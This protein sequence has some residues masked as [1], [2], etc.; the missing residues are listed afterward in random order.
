MLDNIF[1]FLIENHI[2]VAAAESCTG[3]LLAAAFTDVS[4]ISAVF[5]EGAVTYSNEAKERLGVKRE[6]LEKYGAVS[7][8]TAAEMALCIKRRAGS[9]IGISTTGAA[10]PAS[11]EGKPVGLVYTA[12]ATKN[13]T[14]V[15]TLHLNGTRRGIR[16]KAVKEVLNNLKNISETELCHE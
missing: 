11:S 2:T 6:T 4:G 8:E 5:L 10:G 3:G 7:E 16:E 13:K 15:Y 14:Y 1:E 12:I 9:D